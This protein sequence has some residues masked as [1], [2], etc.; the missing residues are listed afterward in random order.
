MTKDKGQ[1]TK[2][3]IHVLCSISEAVY[4]LKK[5]S[6]RQDFKILGLENGQ[7]TKDSIHVLCSISEA[8]YVL[9]IHT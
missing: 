1:R 6:R 5:I 9:K 3:S 4:V 8:I 2:Y 7:L